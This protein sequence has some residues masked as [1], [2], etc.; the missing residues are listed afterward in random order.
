MD[1]NLLFDDEESRVSCSRVECQQDALV[2][3]GE[4]IA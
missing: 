2:D 4:A 3:D 1:G